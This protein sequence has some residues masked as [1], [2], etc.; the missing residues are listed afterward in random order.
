MSAP[1]TPALYSI[2]LLGVGRIG[3]GHA[4][5]LADLP[6]VALTVS[7]LDAERAAAV[8]A[9]LQPASGIRV[10][11]ASIEDVFGNPDRYDGLV[12]AT[13]TSTHEAL[14]IRAASVG[15]PFF[16]E[17]PVAA[18]LEGSRRAMAAVHEAGIASQI[19]FQRRFDPAYTEARR[20]VAAGELG[21]VHRLHMLTCDQFPPSEQFVAHSGGIWRDCLI[22]DIDALRWVTGGEVA[23]VFAYGAVRGEPYFATHGDID[24][25]VALMRMEDDT[26][27]TAQTSRNNGAGY[28]V[29]MEIAGTAGTCVVGLEPKVPLTSAEPGVTFPD[30]EPWTDFIARFKDCYARELRTFVDVV[31]GRATS[32][33]T[34]DDALEALHV[35]LALGRSRELGRPVAVAEV[36]SA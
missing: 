9:S 7:D 33:C 25:G 4:K 14:I 8:A 24:E 11:A 12:I 26:L 32:P 36:R 6:D 22:H 3:V 5:A 30:G 35:A 28:D 13:P 31:A 29:R 1:T 18:D 19:G 10:A 20:R 17:K 16:C 21:Q 27:V 34:I 2:A 15:L 23:E